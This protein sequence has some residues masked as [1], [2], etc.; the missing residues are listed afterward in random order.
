MKKKTLSLLAML[1]IGISLNAQ[2]TKQATVKTS[3]GS[4]L[5]YKYAV[6]S[7]PG[8]FPSLAI[9]L[10]SSAIH[11]MESGDS[12]D[13]QLPNVDNLPY[14]LSELRVTDKANNILKPEIIREGEKSISINVSELL[15]KDI[16]ILCYLSIGGGGQF[17]P[18]TITIINK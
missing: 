10:T 12:F 5:D 16:N 9:H 7:G 3:R 8:T 4:N 11:K 1:L 13:I 6:I 15:Q 17:K 14:K 18:S 2:V